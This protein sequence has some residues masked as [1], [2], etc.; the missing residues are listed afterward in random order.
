MGKEKVV[1]YYNDRFLGSLSEDDCDKLEI[2]LQL[3]KDNG[4]VTDLLHVIRNM[5]ESDAI[6]FIESIDNFGGTFR[7]YNKGIGTLRNEQTIGVALMYW[8]KDCILGDSVGMGKTVEVAGLCNLLKADYERQGKKFRYLL[9]TEKNLSDQVR[10]EMVR[11]TGDYVTLIPS[12]EQR[13]IERF[14]N[15]NPFQDELEYSVVGT[16]ALLTTSGFIG[17][18]EQCRTQGEG[19]P[20]DLIIIDES[21][22]LGG[23]KGNEIV[24]GYKAIEKYFSRHVF[25]NATPFE[26]KLEIFYNQLSLLDK[27][28][29]PTL[30][31][32]KKEY[33]IMD[34]RGMYPK[35]TGKY[36]NQGNFKRLIGYRYFARTRRDKGAVMEDC[37]GGVI[38]SPLSQIQ[39]EW[40]QK[41]QLHRVVYDCPSHLDPTIEFNSENVPK[42]GSLSNLLK[43]ECSDAETILLFVYF[44]EAQACLSKWLTDKGY[45][46][47]VLNGDTSDED[48]A[49]IIKGFKNKEYRVLITNVQKGLN[50][51]DC[52]YCIFY[53]FDPNPSMMIQFEGRTT[54][55]F[56]IIGKNVYILCSLGKEY[57]QLN[58]V[59]RE[60]AQATSD[61]TNTDLS[62]VMSILL[63]L[64]Q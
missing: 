27:N 62:V 2:L 31:N 12:G 19:F 58:D 36:K 33:C 29:L 20:F 13:M 59:V 11:F 47:K 45:S 42:L 38:L 60:R 64:K 43:D 54:R 24:K 9:L 6:D 55:S 53:S 15:S 61:L 26:T 3:D 44:K 57:K 10:T 8:A 32:F 48:R 23:K 46:N 21:S 18:L 7:E 28:M 16:H 49:S 37:A 5:S 41:T 34:Y 22:P 63:R 35:P 14:V 50:F 4:C 52:N 17:W 1:N 30:T 56:D 39:K 25:L 51:G 40:L